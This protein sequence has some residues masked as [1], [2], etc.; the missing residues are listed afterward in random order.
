M[1]ITPDVVASVLAS[2]SGLTSAVGD[3][4]TTSLDQFGE[5]K[6]VTGDVP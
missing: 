6:A 4:A 1:T 3:Q 2:A 5:V